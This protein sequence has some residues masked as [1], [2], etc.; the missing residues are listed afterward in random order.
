MASRSWGPAVHH[1]AS[2]RTK[3][4][5]IGNG[6]SATNRSDT[7][8]NKMKQLFTV[9]TFLKRPKART[10]RAFPKIA[11]MMI[12]PIPSAVSALCVSEKWTADMVPHSKKR[13][14]TTPNWLAFDKLVR[15]NDGMYLCQHFKC[16]SAGE[17]SGLEW[18]SRAK[19][20][21]FSSG[22]GCSFCANLDSCQWCK[23]G[24]LYTCTYAYTD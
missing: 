9:R 11:K 18:A 16:D 23:N 6:T 10:T 17:F 14:C 15:S 24:L 7:A 13:Q 12:R 22:I 2:E 21:I 8:K 19:G 5:H 20:E 3:V 1:V 4:I